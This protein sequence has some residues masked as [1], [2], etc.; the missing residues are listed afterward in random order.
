[1]KQKGRLQAG[2]DADITVFD[3]TTV[4][5]KATF[6]GGLEFS[7]GVEYVFVG[8]VLVLDKGETVPSVFPGQAVY[9][10]FRQ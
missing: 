1:M 9:G 10:R 4:S 8:G 3:P 7:E 5:D 2:A 6:E